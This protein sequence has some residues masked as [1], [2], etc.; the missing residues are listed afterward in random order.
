M[1]DDDA[2]YD[3][4]QRKRILFMICVCVNCL[5]INCKLAHIDWCIHIQ[6]VHLIAFDFVI[7]LVYGGVTLQIATHTELFTA[8]SARMWLLA[9][10]RE[11][12]KHH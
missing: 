10:T 4:K 2:W 6:I 11:K 9:C 12:A 1:L 3:Y 5:P 7:A 8:H